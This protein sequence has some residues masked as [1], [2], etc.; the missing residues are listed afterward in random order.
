VNCTLLPFKMIQNA[1]NGRGSGS[2]THLK[3]LMGLPSVLWSSF[4]QKWWSRWVT[5]PHELACRAS[6]LLVC[7]DPVNRNSYIANENGRLP[8][9]RPEWT[10]FWR[11]CRVLTRSLK[12][13]I[14][15]R[16]SKIQMVRSPGVA[17]G[18]PPWRGDILLLN[19]N[20]GN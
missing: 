17:P 13:K 18:R 12:S 7:H 19:H 8:P 2:C 11:L 16:K 14:G 6:A 4:P 5:L 3:K 1:S 10:E 9:C 15:N 20:R